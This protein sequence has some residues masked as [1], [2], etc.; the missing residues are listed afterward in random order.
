MKHRPYCCDA[1]RD[2]YEEYY[3]QQNG[4]KIPVFAGRKL[5]R[6]HGLGG[7]F[8]RL[9]LPFITTH[10]SRMLENAF[11]TGI[12]VADDVLE[13]R[14]SIVERIYQET[15]SGGYKKNYAG[16]ESPVWFWN[17]EEKK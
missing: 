4:G 8:R 5:Q 15:S 2:L 6:D 7:F 14:R 9:V 10:G 11:K 16:P 3:S 1:N 13:G 12:D 17:Q